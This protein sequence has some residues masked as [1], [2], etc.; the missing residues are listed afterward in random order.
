MSLSTLHNKPIGYDFG[1]HKKHQKEKFLP[2]AP[3]NFRVRLEL[4]WKSYNKVKLKISHTYIF[5][6]LSSGN[7]GTHM[8]IYFS[9]SM[10]PTSLFISLGAIQQEN[11]REHF[12][13]LWLESVQLK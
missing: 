1:M 2:G 6:L 13:G 5:P 10:I 8:Y 9:L 12:S 4:N 3:K 11:G 7:L